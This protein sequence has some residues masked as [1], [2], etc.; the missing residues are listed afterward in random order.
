MMFLLYIHSRKHS[1]PSP[2]RERCSFTCWNQS[3]NKVPFCSC[4]HKENATY[5]RFN[6]TRRLSWIVAGMHGVWLVLA[7]VCHKQQ[8]NLMQKTSIFTAHATENVWKEEQYPQFSVTWN[9]QNSISCVGVGSHT[10]ALFHE[11]KTLV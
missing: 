10:K 1:G 6:S 4:S 9:K 11:I 3:C 8:T 7:T 2:Q 5:H